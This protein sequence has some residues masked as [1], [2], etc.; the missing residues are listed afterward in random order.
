ML[1]G[2][3]HHKTRTEVVDKLKLEV[4]DL[5][6]DLKQRKRIISTQQQLLHSGSDSY[7]KVTNLQLQILDFGGDNNL[8]Y[9]TMMILNWFIGRSNLQT[10]DSPV[11]KCFKQYA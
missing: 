2:Q 4:E 5:K 6:K 11:I 9:I 1:Y 8:E 7:N 10:Q 3:E